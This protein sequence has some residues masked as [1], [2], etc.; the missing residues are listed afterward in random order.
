MLRITVRGLRKHLNKR[1]FVGSDGDSMWKRLTSNTGDGKAGILQRNDEGAFYVVLHIRE[2]VSVN[3][4]W[5]ETNQRYIPKTGDVIGI[6]A[7][8]LW[9]PYEVSL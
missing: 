5:T 2:G 4:P 6:R 8:D 9:R 3:N 1:V 7:R